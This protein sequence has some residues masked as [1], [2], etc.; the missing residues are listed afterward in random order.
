MSS[1]NMETTISSTRLIA[2]AIQT[3]NVTRLAASSSRSGNITAISYLAV[4]MTEII[5]AKDIYSAN[6]PKSSGVY[7]RVN[8]GIAAIGI[9]CA[10][11]VPV[12]SV[13]T[14]RRKSFFPFFT[15]R[16]A[17]ST[18]SAPRQWLPG[19]P[20]PDTDASA[21]SSPDQQS[22]HRPATERQR[23]PLR[24]ACSAESGSARL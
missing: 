23:Q 5:P 15:A 22:R 7:R 3:D 14:L 17:F 20:G 12:I 21:G 8:K 13:N 10:S 11:V 16:N 19:P 1:L 4:M 2:L 24:V 18:L 9:A 6:T